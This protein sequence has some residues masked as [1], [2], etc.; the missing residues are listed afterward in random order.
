MTVHKK[1]FKTIILSIL[2]GIAAG[3]LL[4]A[5]LGL[6]LPPGIPREV[7]TLSKSFVLEPFTL[8]L[9]VLSFTFGISFTFNLLSILGIFVVIQLL[10]WSW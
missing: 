3:S 6:M 2:L 9:L 10:K 7:L 4:G 5:L 1:S 8:N